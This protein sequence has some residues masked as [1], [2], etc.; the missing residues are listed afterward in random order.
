MEETEWA[1]LMDRGSNP[2]AEARLIRL[3]SVVACPGC[4]N[5]SLEFTSS[6][7]TCTCGR[8]FPMIG[9]VPDFSGTDVEAVTGFQYQWEKRRDGAF[10]SATLYGKTANEEEDQFYRFLGIDAAATR[11]KV[12][13]DAGCG[14]GRLVLM[15]AR[16]MEVVGID[17]TSSVMAIDQE[18]RSSG[19]ESITLIRGDLLALPLQKSR[20]DYV[21]SGG[22]I[23]HT[24]DTRAALR[25]LAHVLKPGGVI[26]V[27]VYSV[28]Q[29]IFGRIRQAIPFAHRLPHR[30]LLGLCWLLAIPVWLLGVVGRRYHSLAEI[31]FKLFDHLSPKYR[32]VHSETQMKEW[33]Q[34]EGL[35]QIEI[36]VP[37]RTGG[38]GI[39]G[40]KRG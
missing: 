22:V 39:R 24:G 3:M 16:N 36:V 9:Y 14:S 31:R 27:W 19:L 10:E 26:Y 23:H 13:L 18:A 20:F 15:L 4:G 25:N 37:Q 2:G 21:W 17:L 1:I 34:A 32:T 35:E 7:L 38:V 6:S 29:G 33:F 30:L 40:R 8:S 12:A 5:P 11:G 28:D